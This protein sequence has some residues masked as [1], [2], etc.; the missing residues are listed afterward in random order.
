MELRLE[1]ALAQTVEFRLRPR[2][3]ETD[4]MGMVYYAN[5]LVWFECARSE[6]LRSLGK[7]YA[8]LES[9]GVYLPVRRCEIEY[10]QPARYDRL[11]AVR[12][13]VT[14]LTP[15]RVQ[16]AYEVLDVETGARLAE[17]M[18]VH[19]FVDAKGKIARAGFKALGIEG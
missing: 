11:T 16:F 15:V 9:E 19:A 13:R 3:A 17:G 12:A 10:R 8:A 14:A 6:W 18:T 7:T 5:Y 1:E 4:Q 2:Y